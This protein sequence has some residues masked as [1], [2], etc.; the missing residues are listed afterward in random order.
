[1][2]CW[3]RTLIEQSPGRFALHVDAPFGDDLECACKLL[4]ASRLED[5]PGRSQFERPPDE[6]GVVVHRQHHDGY[7]RMVLAKPFEDFE[8]RLALHL[9][10]EDD[11][12]GH[13]PAIQYASHRRAVGSVGDDLDVGRLGKSPSESVA[14]GPVIVDDE[15]PHRSP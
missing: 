8:P 7:G 14:Y 6:N 4:G 11:H 15:D 10:V 13:G 12:I 5:V 1:M 3:R 2:G 9:D